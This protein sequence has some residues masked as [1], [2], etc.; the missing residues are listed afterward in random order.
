MKELQ[1][2][3]VQ[4]AKSAGY[5]DADWRRS[6]CKPAAWLRVH[7]LAIGWRARL[8]AR[9]VSQTDGLH[10][11]HAAAAVTHE[12]D[13][14]KAAFPDRLHLGILA[15]DEWTVEHLLP[16]AASRNSARRS[17]L[18]PPR[19]AGLSSHSP[20]AVRTMEPIK[21][22]LLSPPPLDLPS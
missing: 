14:P 1:N 11:A 8:F 10:D 20:V 18:A 7:S 13:G 3:T 22:P 6:E 19:L 2:R 12:P 5:A 16:G 21:R 15:T 17:L 4:S 9:L